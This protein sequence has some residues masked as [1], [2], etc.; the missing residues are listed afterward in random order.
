MWM[1]DQGVR[2]CSWSIT[3]VCKAIA[4]IQW[5]SP[6]A[7]ATTVW[8]RVSRRLKNAW[9]NC[10]NTVLCRWHAV[11]NKHNVL[12]CRV[13]GCM[14]L[15]FLG[16]YSFTGYTDS[17]GIFRRHIRCALKAM[18][19]I[20]GSQVCMWCYA[21]GVI[22]ST[23]CCMFY[24]CWHG[25]AGAVTTTWGGADMYRG[26]C[27]LDTVVYLSMWAILRLTP[28]ARKIT[29]NKEAHANTGRTEI[30]DRQESTTKKVGKQNK[31]ALFNEKAQFF[32]LPS[33][34]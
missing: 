18:L 5:Y 21:P 22:A 30:K 28:N 8:E 9:I 31:H 2:P 14:A 1:H 12:G 32:G 11:A 4:H 26:A 24:R 25:Q 13:Q 34:F 10:S 17:S 3:G 29:R 15:Y 27:D 20:H 16:R 7:N 6:R 23:T 19:S 33:S